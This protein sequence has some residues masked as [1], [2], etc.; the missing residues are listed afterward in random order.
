[1]IDKIDYSTSD[2]PVSAS[3]F[4]NMLYKTKFNLHRE[5]G[6]GKSEVVRDIDSLRIEKNNVE[7]INEKKPEP[8]ITSQKIDVNYAF[9]DNMNVI[10]ERPEILPKEGKIAEEKQLFSKDGEV[11]ASLYGSYSE[12]NAED[13]IYYISHDFDKLP[14]YI[15]WTYII[16]D[17]DYK[18]VNEYYF[19]I[20]ISEIKIN[21][22]DKELI[23]EEYERVLGNDGTYDNFRIKLKE[24][25]SYRKDACYVIESY[26]AKYRKSEY[27]QKSVSVFRPD[28]KSL[29]SGN[30]FEGNIR[31]IPLKDEK[32]IR[33]V[34]ING[35]AKDGFILDVSR[36]SSAF[37]EK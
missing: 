6:F 30:E 17:D 8:K 9:D 2:E 14:S 34:I 7:N 19:D 27:N 23:P 37:A 16:Y 3:E 25:Q 33:E 32:H 15:R 20:D 13:I 29:K 4:L 1:M 5:G 22:T 10:L 21:F 11:I 28:E 26:D 35:N 18:R 31:F 36:E 12:L 24:G